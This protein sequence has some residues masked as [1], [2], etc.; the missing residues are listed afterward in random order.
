MDDYLDRDYCDSNKMICKDCIG[1]G[2]LKEYIESYGENGTC[3]Y[4]D[5]NSI[6]IALD[7]LME[8]IM[9]SLYTMFDKAVEWLPYD[10][11]EGGYQGTTYDSY[12]LIDYIEQDIDAQDDLIIEDIRSLI[13]PD[14]W[15]DTNPY[16]LGVVENDI[17]TGQKFCNM[18]KHQVRYVFYSIQEE[19]YEIYKS[20]SDILH[21]IGEGVLMF[22]LVKYIDVGTIF[23]RGRVHDESE[24]E[25][26]YENLGPPPSKVASFNRMN[27]DG[28]SMFYGAFKK[29]VAIKEIIDLKKFAVTIARFRTSNK[30]IL[31]D[32]V[33]IVDMVVPSIF[34]TERFTERMLLIFLKEFVKNV[35][36]RVV[37]D[38]R[39]DYVPTQVV[40]EYFRHVF[41]YGNESI[42][43]IIYPSSMICGEECVVL[44]TES[45]KS[46][47]PSFIDLVVGSSERILVSDINLMV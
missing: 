40:T 45:G 31:V 24:I 43:G 42:D 16:G 34:D 18:L 27:P 2:F 26:S 46:S 33:K 38:N 6:V 13:L 23:Y 32:L 25:E 47:K 17:F 35:S 19:D 30:L 7:N 37:N 22:K 39:L 15:C 12:E 20:P 14:I 29:E 3:D 8:P 1:D 5:E 36:R 44:F 11:R 9:S 41:K 28:I 21:R 10:T 4:C